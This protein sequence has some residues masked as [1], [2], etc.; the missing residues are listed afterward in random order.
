MK[1]AIT[2]R[3]NDR[4]PG[5]NYLHQTIENALRAGIMASPHLAAFDIVASHT[6]EGEFR[7]EAG[8]YCHAGQVQVERGQSWRINLHDPRRVL[9]PNECATE[10]HAI[11]DSHDADYVLFIE[12]DL[13][14]CAN[15]LESV[16]S[17]L[18]EY[19]E[20]QY[21]LFVF[22][23]PQISSTRRG[24]KPVRVKGFYG[25]QCY[26]IPKR[27]HSRLVQWLIENPLYRGKSRCH[28]LRLHNW[29]EELRVTHFLASCPSFVQHV[30]EVSGMGC[31]RVHFP[32]WRGRDWSYLEEAA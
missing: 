29:A 2:M 4:S 9:S 22:G 30:G 13:D 25:T 12:D 19:A 20:S 23:S 32:S 31:P 10:A 21:P 1:I 24:A 8:Y 27:L 28:D 16:V 14:F 5:P 18:G 17:W 6:L 15:F 11:A 3:T 26:A 7:E